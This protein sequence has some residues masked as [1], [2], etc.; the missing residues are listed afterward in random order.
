MSKD[1]KRDQLH[2]QFLFCLENSYQGFPPLFQPPKNIFTVLE[3]QATSVDLRTPRK[4]PNFSP[5]FQKTHFQGVGR[6]P[7]T[8][9][10]PNFLQTPK[11][12]SDQKDLRGQGQGLLVA[13][14]RHR[15]KSWAIF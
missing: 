14:L 11:K 5:R 2:I 3:D 6:A 7:T 13:G 1:P 9:N 4:P 15:K 10:T 8:P 12:F